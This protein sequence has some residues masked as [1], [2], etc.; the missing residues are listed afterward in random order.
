MIN[1]FEGTNLVQTHQFE[2]FHGVIKVHAC[3]VPI[4]LVLTES[5]AQI[6]SVF[7]IVF[8]LL[9]SAR[10]NWWGEVFLGLFSEKEK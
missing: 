9:N 10:V 7:P 6:S 4:Y 8:S 2:F 5:A 3:A 1:K